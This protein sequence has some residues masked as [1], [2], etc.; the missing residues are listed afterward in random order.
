MALPVAHSAVALAMTRSRDP[1]VWGCLVILSILPDFDFVLVWG[2]GL[3]IN[4]FHR[5]FSH[6][7]LFCVGLAL[8]WW[9]VRPHRLK[10]LSPALVGAVLLSHGF[11]DM[12]CT[13]DALDHGVVFFWPLSNYH[14]GWPILVPLYQWFGTSPF[15]LDGAI[16]FTLL[17]LLLAAPLWISVRTIRDGLRSLAW[18]RWPPES[19]PGSRQLD[20]GELTGAP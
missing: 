17:E 9:W 11:L 19:E 1:L 4:T 10:A 20:Q 3:P 18:K 5:T 15:S 2:F 6:S 13:S 7:L 14:M 12:L 16:R 8:V